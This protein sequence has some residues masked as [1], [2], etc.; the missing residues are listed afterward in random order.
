MLEDDT[1]NI[2]LIG[3]YGGTFDPLHYGHLRIAEELVESV[4]FSKLYFIP[5]GSPRLRQAP[6][7]SM[8]HRVAML[9][10]AIQGNAKFTVDERE[11]HRSGESRSVVTLRELKHEFAENVVLCFLMGMDVFVKLPD[12]YCW[13]ELFKLCH[14]VIVDRPG[15]ISLNNKNHLSEELNREVLHRQATHAS[16]LKN[17][18]SGRVLT[19]PTTM[20]DISATLIRDNIA[21]KKSIRYLLPDMVLEYIETNH[22]YF[23][24]NFKALK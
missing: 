18:C 24:K 1:T 5:S 9:R 10:A 8:Y 16:E 13:R 11:I 7:A 3:I 21:N 22:L 2:S 14:I 6:G 17:T 12:W 23:P 20:L 19:V 4:G 15:C